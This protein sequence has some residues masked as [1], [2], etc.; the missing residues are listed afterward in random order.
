[1]VSVQGV[2]PQG[3]CSGG[4]W[5]LS[6]GVESEEYVSINSDDEAVCTFFKLLFQRYQLLLKNFSVSK[7][8]KKIEIQK[9]IQ[10]IEQEFIK[11]SI[12]LNFKETSNEKCIL[13]EEPQEVK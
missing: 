8:K 1:L 9:Q 2:N 5:Y 13:V 12:H 3:H 10:K 7:T 6:H 4:K 11:T